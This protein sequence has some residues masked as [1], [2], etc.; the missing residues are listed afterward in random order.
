MRPGPLHCQGSASGNSSTWNWSGDL[1]TG[2][3]MELEL[4]GTVSNCRC[5][6][7]SHHREVLELIGQIGVLVQNGKIC[8]THLV[9]TV[10]YV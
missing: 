4:M 7:K 5:L 2:Q 1:A 6:A 8:M 10:A 9:K 3:G